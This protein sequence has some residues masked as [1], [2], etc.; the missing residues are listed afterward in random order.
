VVVDDQHWY[1]ALVGSICDRRDDG[2]WA[3]V[4]KRKQ[5]QRSVNAGEVGRTVAGDGCRAIGFDGES[6]VPEVLCDAL[7]TSRRCSSHRQYVGLWKYNGLAEIRSG[8]YVSRSVWSCDL[9]QP[10]SPEGLGSRDSL[11]QKIE[12]FQDLQ[13]SLR[14]F[15]TTASPG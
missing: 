3:V 6:A 1:V 4:V 15:R 5:F 9:R 12:D 8:V 13:K 11:S 7:A 10:E 2:Q 14:L